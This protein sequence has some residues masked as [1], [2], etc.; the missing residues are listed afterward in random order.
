MG[1]VRPVAQRRDHQDFDPFERA[2]ALLRNEVDVGD[3]RER[4]DPP[5]ID[6]HI[7]V[8]HRH[9]H[10]PFAE[11]LERLLDG[12]QVETRLAA[13]LLALLEHVGEDLAQARDGGRRAVARDR[14]ALPEVVDAQVVEPEDVVGVRVGEK[15][16]VDAADVVGERLD[17]EIGGRVDQHRSDRRSK[18]RER[19]VVQ[20]DQDRGPGPAIAR[21]AGP[22]H[23]TVAPDRRHAVRRTAAEHGHFHQG[24]T[25]RL[26][27]P[28]ASTKRM[29]SS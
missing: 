4:P 19:R 17:A 16:G 5:A 28:V 2:P 21:I 8:H 24:S 27:V 20:L 25:I 1:R 23:L 10:D 11:Q 9:R 22:A 14:R 26:A 3:H 7:A 15:N 12:D 13:P 18:G 6:R 29:R